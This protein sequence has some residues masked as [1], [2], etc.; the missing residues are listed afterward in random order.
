LRAGRCHGPEAPKGCHRG[1]WRT[2]PEEHPDG[3]DHPNDEHPKKVEDLH[4]RHASTSARAARIAETAPMLRR[5]GSIL[6]GEAAAAAVFFLCPLLP[7]VIHL[8]TTGR[9]V[10]TGKLGEVLGDRQLERSK[11]IHLCDCVVECRRNAPRLPV[12]D[13]MAAGGCHHL[14]DLQLA[15]AY[16]GAPGLVLI[17]RGHD[18]VTPTP[19]H[20]SLCG[21]VRRLVHEP[22]AN[23]WVERFDL[24]HVASSECAYLRAFQSTGVCMS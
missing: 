20:R 19:V 8:V 12:G 15:K 17:V 11:H 22:P 6:L 18:P 24:R 9:G 14:R 10:A 2:S 21:P 13:P 23:A 5:R 4:L 3:H 16:I 1:E 7:I